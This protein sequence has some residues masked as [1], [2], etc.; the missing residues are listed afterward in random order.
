[1]QRKVG[2]SRAL[3]LKSVSCPR[4]PLNR[5]L[6][7]DNY[8]SRIINYVKGEPAFAHM[9]YKNV[10]QS[11]VVG[12]LAIGLGGWL[13]SEMVYVKGTAVEAVEK[14]A[15]KVEESSCRRVS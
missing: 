13:G 15:K 14:L 3:H 7:G 5:N 2:N 11:P 4:R 1:M 9:T 6:R 10:N 8:A 12:V